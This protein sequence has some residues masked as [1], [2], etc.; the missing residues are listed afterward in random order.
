MLTFFPF[1]M[2]RLAA[3]R[4]PVDL[5]PTSVHTPANHTMRNS[6]AIMIEYYYVAYCKKNTLIAV[7]EQ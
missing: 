7:L 5:E 4:C 2:T 3:L 1:A 6:L